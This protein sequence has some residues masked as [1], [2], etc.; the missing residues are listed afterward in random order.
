MGKI[1]KK[2]KKLWPAATLAV[3]LA[4][5]VSGVALASAITPEAVI[6]LVNQARL[7]NGLNILEENNKLSQAAAEKA[8][9]MVSH[10][11]FAHNSPKGIT[12]WFWIEK[13]KYEYVYAGENL[14]MDF[15]TAEKEQQAWMN[16]A[17]HKKNI[18]NPNYQEIGVA[19]KQGMINGHLTT[20]AVQ[21]F[22]S[23]NDFVASKNPTIVPAKESEL[24]KV[25]SEEPNAINLPIALAPQPN[26]SLANSFDVQMIK[27]SDKA[28]KS[29]KYA[30]DTI[31][32]PSFLESV[33]L[34]AYSVLIAII[35]VINPLA[36]LYLL[37]L[38]LTGKVVIF[39]S[40]SHQT[41]TEA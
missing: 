34:G 40:T 21:E 14:A 4:L 20:I 9:D 27:I 41:K 29:F 38:I 17:S 18:L 3:F 10:N 13:N 7:G 35:L 11:Y 31:N 24:E 33:D 5:A 25:S 32:S 23:R 36:M 37:A 16:S 6:G 28:I 30:K 8:E 26:A 39:P 19:V 1:K 15:M 22:G 2:I 12:P